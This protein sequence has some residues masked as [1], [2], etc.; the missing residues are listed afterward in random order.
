M[1]LYGWGDVQLGRVPLRETFTVNE[2]GG[3]GR[4]LDLEGQESYP[5]LTRAQVIA[6]HDGINSLIAGQVVPVTFTDK[7]ERS[8]YYTVKSNGASYSEH[9]NERVTT[10]WKVSLDRVGSDSETDLQSRL[11]GAVRLNDFSLT[12]ERWH[13]PPIGHYGY[14]TGSSNPTTMTRTGA[15]GTM[16][17]YR[18][19]PASVSPRWGCPPT[20]YL[21]GRVKATTTG[22]Q[23]VYGADVPL[24]ATGW[25]LS[26]SFVNV[27]TSASGSLD[28]QTYSDGAYHSKLW[29]VSVAGSGA[30]IAS[31]DGATLLRNDPEQVILRLTKSLSPGRATLDLTLRRGSRFI[32][33]YLQT[34]TAATLC[35]YRSSLETNTS[36]AASGYVTA[37]G[38]DADGN[39]FV[40]GS[41]RT[42]TAHPNGGVIK[43]AATG[44]DFFIG[45]VASQPTLNANP[46]FETNTADWNTTNATLTRSNAQ[47]KYG[48]WSGLLTTTAGSA[49][50]VQSSLYAVT[51]GQPYRG[52]GWL[53]APSPIPSGVAVNVNWFD[54]SQ[55]YLTTSANSTTPAS[56]AW[57]F[58][59]AAFTA[60]VGAVYGNVLYTVNGSPGAGVL[61]YGDDVRL[62]GATPSG[63]TALDLRNQYIAAMPE[64]VYGARR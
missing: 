31:W 58:M 1:G 24:A 45:A 49:P 42:F 59:D 62:R 4:T 5:P 12:G 38:D 36:F 46:T 18:S 53:H 33:G 41:A 8:G 22:G 32:E 48:S 20:S 63:D 28:V 61:L 47:A 34:G 39:Q 54:A 40:C 19:V 7:P 55:V 30:S 6:R 37:A 44:L 10:D 27:T 52:S 43:S 57:F 3:D 64:A 51:A 60:P 2:A 23:E 9:L 17:V 13:A 11:T 29:N 56:G 15:D 50:R 14:Y 21:A 16:T 25:S 26:N 35:A